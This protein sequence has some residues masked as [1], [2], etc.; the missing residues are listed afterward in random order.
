MGKQRK[1]NQVGNIRIL[2][3]H[4]QHIRAL[5]GTPDIL[6]QDVSQP[7]IDFLIETGFH[8]KFN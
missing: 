2:S 5:V 3:G 6:I 1:I 8:Y 7:L 4:H